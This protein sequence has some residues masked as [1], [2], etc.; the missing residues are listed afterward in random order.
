MSKSKF[1]TIE[2][3]KQFLRDNYA[4]GVDC[5]CCG[6]FVKLY[7]RKLNSSMAAILI[8]VFQHSGREYVHIPSLISS[9]PHLHASL[10]GGDF[11][12]LAH[13]G[14]IAKKDDVR[15]DGSNRTGQW[16]VTK[17]GEQFIKNEIFVAKH[18]FLYNGIFRRY[19]DDG[20]SII[21]ALGNKFNYRELMNAK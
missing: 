18:V 13:W 15:D 10:G 14:L 5:P 7:K 3:A 12:K 9:L 4:D 8:A 11:S 19:S 21:D 6:Q 17:K 1:K 16:R 2:E 20:I